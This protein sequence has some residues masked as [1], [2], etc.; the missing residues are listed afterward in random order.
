MPRCPPQTSP[1]LSPPPSRAPRNNQK[2]T[3]SSG[4][5][6]ECLR[7]YGNPEVWK[8]FTDLFDYLPLTGLVEGKVRLVCARRAAS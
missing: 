5:Y 2:N 3:K 6:D 7:K 1:S 8:H 4:F